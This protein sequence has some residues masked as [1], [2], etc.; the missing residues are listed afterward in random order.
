MA[1]LIDNKKTD[2][3]TVFFPVSSVKEWAERLSA[4]D[5]IAV[6]KSYDI[7][8]LDTSV[9]QVLL[10]IAGSREALQNALSAH[11]LQLVD[12]GHKYFI[13]TKP[14]NH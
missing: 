4:L 8:S 7:I 13:S 12:E 11:R 3:M 1:N 9:G 5:K 10:S 14:K 2:Y 6:I